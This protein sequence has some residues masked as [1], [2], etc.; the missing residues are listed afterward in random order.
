MIYQ[1]QLKKKL[2]YKDVKHKIG[3]IIE[4]SEKDIRCFAGACKVIKKISELEEEPIQVIRVA[5]ASEKEDILKRTCSPDPIK[6]AEK[7]FN[8]LV[9]WLLYNLDEIKQY[10]KEMDILQSTIVYSTC[11]GGQDLNPLEKNIFAVDDAKQIVS[12]VETSIKNFDSDMFDIYVD[13]YQNDMLYDKIA[14]FEDISII[15]VKRAIKH[16]RELV[17][18]DFDNN[19]ISMDDVLAF[20][21]KLWTIDHKKAS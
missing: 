11:P 14:E 6:T 2:K 10:I 16:I 17:I 5:P 12:S 15:T 1:V 7:V 4:V 18:S 13:R 21:K 8:K 3:E 20:R 19:E 9:D